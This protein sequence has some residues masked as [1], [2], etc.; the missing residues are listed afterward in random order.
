MSS[1]PA[2]K[3]SILILFGIAAL[4]LALTG[5]SDIYYDRRET[6]ALHAGDAGAS[7]RVTHV[8]DP[9]SQASGNNRIAYNGE[10]MQAAAQRYRTGRIIPPV[11]AMTSSSFATPQTQTPASPGGSSGAASGGGNP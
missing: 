2:I 10:R 3:S 4:S 7:N 11:N 6:I 5:C 9:W 8:I 1:L